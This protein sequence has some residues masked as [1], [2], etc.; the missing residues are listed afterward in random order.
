MSDYLA[1]VVVVD[2]VGGVAG[3][4]PNIL[5]IA[6]IKAT[7]SVLYSATDVFNGVGICGNDSMI[8][9]NTAAI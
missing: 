7:A 9:F 4:S 2:V 8:R 1:A 5:Q 3:F 6:W